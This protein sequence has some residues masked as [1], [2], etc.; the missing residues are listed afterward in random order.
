MPNRFTARKIN[1]RMS[2]LVWLDHMHILKRMISFKYKRMMSALFTVGNLINMETETIK[3]RLWTKI[4]PVLCFMSD[5]T[6]MSW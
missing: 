1:D 5:L 3:R 4:R 2:L 6:F